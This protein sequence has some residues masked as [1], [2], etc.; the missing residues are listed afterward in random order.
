[1]TSGFIGLKPKSSSFE[2][3]A[4]QRSLRH[5]DSVYAAP[6]EILMVR[7]PRSERLEPTRISVHCQMIGSGTVLGNSIVCPNQVFWIF[8]ISPSDSTLRIAALI[9]SIS[10]LSSSRPTQEK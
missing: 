6:V 7:S 2:T 8:A 3:R 5:E 1:M 10:D 4:S 9:A